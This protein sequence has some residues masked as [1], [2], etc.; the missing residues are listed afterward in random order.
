M[1]E[2][3]RAPLLVLLALLLVVAAVV[4]TAKSSPSEAGAQLAERHRAAV[5]DRSLPLR[6]MLSEVE[7]EAER[8]QEGE[9]R[10]AFLDAYEKGMAPV[11]AEL[12]ALYL[13]AAAEDLGAGL[14]FVG[15]AAQ[16]TVEAVARGVADAAKKAE[17]PETA[18]E[19]GRDF[20]R[21]VHGVAAWFEAFAEGVEAE[22]ERR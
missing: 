1:L 19:A 4:L 11:R 3:N 18:R 17:D 16:A 10:D 7:T 12:S 20:G 21:A 15:R 8:H 22:V 6:S 14:G 9:A 5:L 2:G 13:E